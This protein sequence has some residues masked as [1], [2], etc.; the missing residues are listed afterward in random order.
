[1]QR[2]I[3]LHLRG[4]SYVCVGGRRVSRRALGRPVGRGSLSFERRS[5]V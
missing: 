2:R 3:W 5:A 4:I 1:M